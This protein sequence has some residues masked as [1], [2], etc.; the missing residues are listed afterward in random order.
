MTYSD[1][2]KSPKWQKKRLEI[3]SLKDFK[4]EVCNNEDNHGKKIH[5]YK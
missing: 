3:L 4:C 1:K 2:L 5:R